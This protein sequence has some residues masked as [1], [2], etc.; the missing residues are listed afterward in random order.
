[1]GSLY[2]SVEFEMINIIPYAKYRHGLLEFDLNYNV[3][4]YLVEINKNFT[5][6]QLHYLLS[7]RSSHS[8]KLYKLLYQYKN[9]GKRKFAVSI[10]KEQFGL[11]KKY[12]QYKDFKK[13]VIIP[14]I[15]QINELTDLMVDYTE[16]KVGRKVDELEFIFRINNKKPLVNNAPIFDNAIEIKPSQEIKKTKLPEIDKLLSA[17]ESELSDKT[18]K[19]IA[20]AYKDN[21]VE[22]IE[23]SIKYATKHSKSNLDKYLHDTLTNRWADVEVQKILNKKIEEQKQL[24]ITKQKQQKADARLKAKEQ[25]KIMVE[26]EWNNLPNKQQEKYTKYAAHLINKYN[27]KLNIFPTIVEDL[28]ICCYAVSQNKSYNLSIEG[29]CETI[30]NELLHV[31]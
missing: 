3:I 24:Q 26:V 2:G 12:S 9:I 20:K 23:A 1:M 15:L 27:Q 8:I 30:L 21:G 16:I 29:F 13:K 10:L 5:E 28:P 19:L 22:Y 7:L 11:S 25:K 18:K 6:Y 31:V 4:P 17:I 14:S